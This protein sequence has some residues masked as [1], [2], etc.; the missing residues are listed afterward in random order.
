MQPTTDADR[1]KVFRVPVH[2]AGGP[3]GGTPRRSESG[4]DHLQYVRRVRT[5]VGVTDRDWA[6]F[7]AARPE[8]EEVNFWLPNPSTGFAA[9]KQGEPFLFK[10]HYPDNSLVGGGFFEGCVPLRVSEAWKFFGEG[11]GVS[12][13][14]ALLAKT[15][16][17]RRS[18]S[19]Q[20]SGPSHELD[21]DDPTIG[22][23][24]L[25]G[26][27]WFGEWSLPAPTSFAKNIVRGKG[28]DAGTDSVVDLA[29]GRLMADHTA[30]DV[31][32]DNRP[33]VALGPTHGTPRLVVPRMNQGAFRAVVLDVYESRCAITGHRIRPT[34]QAAHIRPVAHGGEHR[35]DNGLLLRSDIHTLFDLGYVT[36]DPTY[37]LRVSARLREDFGNGEDL[38][39]RETAGEQIALP[40][41]PGDR[42]SREALE[43]HGDTT[44]LAG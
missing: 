5:Y 39:A 19:D 7:L 28:Y 41:G 2:P 11:N 16:K 17:Y 27:T 25:N 23:V 20:G 24:M 18:R 38:Y 9:L 33:A 14:E 3:V 6:A 31:T 12:D 13:A 37:R 40:R 1:R 44:F 4:V 42:P 35:V 30:A 21:H 34:L 29:L 22:C 8:L 15:G 26:V 36:V 43:W 10:T 32:D